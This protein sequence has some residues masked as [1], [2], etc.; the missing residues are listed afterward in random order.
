[1]L[2]KIK[3]VGGEEQ[4][5]GAGG[6]GPSQDSGFRIRDSGESMKS[7]CF[8]LSA[9]RFLLSASCFLP[10]AYCRLLLRPATPVSRN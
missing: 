5:S 9:S 10:T 4:V 3:E 1:M 8:L 2:L 6:Q 7:I